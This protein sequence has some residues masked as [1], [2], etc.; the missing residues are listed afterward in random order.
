M[1]KLWSNVY[2]SLTIMR[3]HSM[4]IWSF[5]GTGKQIDE[6]HYFSSKPLRHVIHITGTARFAGQ[7]NSQKL[8]SLRKREKNDVYHDVRLTK[9]IYCLLW[10]WNTYTCIIAIPIATPIM[11]E[12]LLFSWSCRLFKHPYNKQIQEII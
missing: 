8:W 11:I 3:H 7:Q 12:R 6:S 2:R 9:I 10:L 5:E 1:T 4:S